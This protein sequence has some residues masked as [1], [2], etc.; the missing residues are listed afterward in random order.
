MCDE[1]WFEVFGGWPICDD[2]LTNKLAFWY[3][4]GWFMVIVGET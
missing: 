1:S 4:E 3:V 2:S